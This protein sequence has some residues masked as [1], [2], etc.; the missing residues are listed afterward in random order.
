MCRSGQDDLLEPLGSPVKGTGCWAESGGTGFGSGSG[1]IGRRAPSGG[2]GSP[3]WALG[4]GMGPGTGC[5]PKT[6]SGG[7]ERSGHPS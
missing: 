3:L 7:T 1:A 2:T 6:P 5:P 4:C